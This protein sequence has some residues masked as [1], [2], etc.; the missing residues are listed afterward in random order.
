MK[1]VASGLMSN[2]IS[3]GERSTGDTNTLAR[4]SVCVSAKA[5]E[6][7]TRPHKRMDTII[8]RNVISSPYPNIT[9]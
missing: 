2:T 9:F 3:S 1:L 4:L 6:L 8:Y 7:I 5:G